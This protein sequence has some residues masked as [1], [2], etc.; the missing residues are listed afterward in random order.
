MSRS[1]GKPPPFEREISE[2]RFIEFT[3]GYR[4][5]NIPSNS[6]HAPAQNGCVQMQRY[7]YDMS[8]S[9]ENADNLP[10]ADSSNCSICNAAL[11]AGAGYVVRIDIFANPAWS[12]SGLP[13]HGPDIQESI[14]HVIDEIKSRD[15]NDL[16]DGIHRRSEYRVCARCQR[17]MLANPLGLPRISRDAAN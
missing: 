13:S 7:T 1:E 6:R 9:F 11:A 17:K 12:N 14:A 4:L 8:N 16:Q 3:V 10:A 2:R 15:V 5:P